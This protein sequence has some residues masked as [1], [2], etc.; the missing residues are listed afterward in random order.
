MA[1]AAQ[2][3]TP[4]ILPA[5]GT[6]YVSNLEKASTGSAA[7]GND[8]WWAQIFNTGTASNGYLLNS[9]QLQMHVSSG[10]PAGFHLSIYSGITPED[11]IDTLTGPDPLASGVYTFTSTGIVLLPSTSYF[12]VATGATPSLQGAYRWSLTSPSP[13]GSGWDIPNIGRYKSTDGTNWIFAGRLDV[14]Q[15]AIYATL[16]PEPS[17]AALL[18]LGLAGLCLWRGRPPYSSKPQC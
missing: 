16:V 8:S 3:V 18:G 5:Q 7:I 13:T 10:T 15:L 17:T 11:R 9:V 12:V 6:V 14:F 2:L 4:S 1:L